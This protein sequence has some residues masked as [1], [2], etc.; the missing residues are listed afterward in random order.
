MSTQRVLL[1]GGCGYIGAHTAWAC[2]ELEPGWEVHLLDTLENSLGPP[3][4]REG[5]PDPVFHRVDTTDEAAVGALLE[6][7]RFDAVV[8]FAAHKSVERSLRDPVEYYR[9]N[10][11]GLVALLRRMA[12]AG[13]F[14]LVFSSSATVYGDATSPLHEDTAPGTLTNPY[15]RS[16]AMCER[17]LRDTAAADP[18]W[19][20]WALRYFN[21]MGAHPSGRLSDRPRGKPCNLMPCLLE[22]VRRHEPFTIF[23]DDYDTPDGTCLRDYIHVVD[24]AEAHV[25]ALRRAIAGGGGGMRVLNLGTGSPRSVREVVDAMSRAAGRPVRVIHGPRR[26]GDCAAVWAAADR[27]RRQLSPWRP[28]RGLREMCEDALR[29]SGPPG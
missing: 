27:A 17:I 7:H 9:N 12:A 2:Q 8:H 5:R 25:E 24:L 18:R 16:K 28:S 1:T 19:R 10:V 20:V 22:A 6:R 11:G 14:A 26:P 3:P 23:G 29:A 13:C 4:S 21:P 15:G